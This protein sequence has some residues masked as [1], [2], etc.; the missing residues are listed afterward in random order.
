MGR[1]SDKQRTVVLKSRAVQ[2]VAEAV[3]TCPEIVFEPN[4]FLKDVMVKVARPSMLDSTFQAEVYISEVEG[5]NQVGPGLKN[6]TSFTIYAK[7]AYSKP[8]QWDGMASSYL[9]EWSM[10]KQILLVRITKQNNFYTTNDYSKFVQWNLQAID[11][12]RTQQ[13][14]SPQTPITIDIPFTNDNSYSKPWYWGNL[15]ETYL[16]T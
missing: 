9:G 13:K 2:G 3:V 15:Q 7:E 12:L 6:F 4:E 1:A 8:R 11:S 10:A 14:K 5:N 16:G